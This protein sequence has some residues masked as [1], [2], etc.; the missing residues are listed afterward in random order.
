MTESGKARTPSLAE[1]SERGPVA[2]VEPLKAIAG[3]VVGSGAEAVNVEGSPLLESGLLVVVA[4]IS[5]LPGP[6]IASLVESVV[7]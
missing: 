5:M 6:R 1:A 4:N 3:R 7:P 2:E